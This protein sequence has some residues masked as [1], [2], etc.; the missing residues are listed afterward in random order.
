MNEYEMEL[1]D[2]FAALLEENTELR[3]RIG[4]LKDAVKAE[5]LKDAD[6]QTR[7]SYGAPDYEGSVKTERINEIFGWERAPEAVEIVEGLRRKE[8]K[9]DESV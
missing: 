5:E 4:I 2:R 7:R 9:V 1:V 3:V 6:Y 8:A